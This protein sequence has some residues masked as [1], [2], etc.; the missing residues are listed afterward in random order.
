MP[1]LRRYAR[2]LLRDMDIADDLVQD[3]LERALSRRHLWRGGLDLRPWLFRILHNVCMNEVRARRTRPVHESID[4]IVDLP[5]GPEGHD[6]R[7]ELQEMETALDQLVEEQRQVILLIALTGLSYRECAQA[8]DV[9]VGTI[10]SRLSRGR[11]RLRELLKD[12]T[13]SPSR[14]L[15][16]IK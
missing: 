4:R 14:V 8:L 9:P 11:E 12:E 13:N 6:A 15:R 1:S 2:A 3:C 16:R 5:A 7:L 10:M